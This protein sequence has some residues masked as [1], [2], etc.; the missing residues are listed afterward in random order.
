MIIMRLCLLLLGGILLCG[1]LQAQT[2]QLGSWTV[3]NARLNLAKKWGVWGELQLRS[4]SFY[5]NFYYYEAKGGL[6]YS[7]NKNFVFLLGSGKYVTYDIS[8]DGN[9][10]K[11][12]VTNETRLWQELNTAQYLDRVKFEHRYRIE[13]RWLNGNYRN[14]FRYR[15]MMALPLNKPKFEKG[16]LFLSAFDEVFFTSKT[17]YFERNRV[18][19]GVGYQATKNLVVLPGYLYQFDYHPDNKS[20]GKHFF[21]LNFLLNLHADPDG[22]IRLPSSVD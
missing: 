2:K 17:P 22:I 18:F 20:A 1:N 7:W 13:Q 6:L 8:E 11:P 12:L 21:Q 3:L 10:N 9:F 5:N 4:Q 16:T 14:R 19:G 15:F